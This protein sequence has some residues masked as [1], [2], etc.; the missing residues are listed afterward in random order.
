HDLPGTSTNV[1]K[2]SQS[3][4]VTWHTQP[5]SFRSGC[6]NRRLSRAHVTG[7][8]PEE[9]SLLPPERLRY[10]VEFDHLRVQKIHSNVAINISG[11]RGWGLGKQQNGG[12]Q[13]DSSETNAAEDSHL[14][15]EPSSMSLRDCAV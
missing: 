7:K 10:E 12:L 9:C 1:W 14:T 3:I 15:F 8:P 6:R 2:N 11:K 13:L 5:A 4:A